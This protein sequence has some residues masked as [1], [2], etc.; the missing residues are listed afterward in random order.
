LQL[1]VAVAQSGRGSLD[2]LGISDA[3]MVWLIPKRRVDHCKL[4]K[5]PRN[6]ISPCGLRQGKAKNRM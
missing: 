5:K 2:D 6:L 4:A 3:Q 1:I